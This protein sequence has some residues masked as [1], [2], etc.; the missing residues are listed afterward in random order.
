MTS[1]TPTPIPRYP[2]DW[3]FKQIWPIFFSWILC[4]LA[5]LG[6]VYMAIKARKKSWLMA[7]IIVTPLYA[8]SLHSATTTE[9]DTPFATFG[10]IL[11]CIFAIGFS[12]RKYPEFLKILDER[13][14]NKAMQP[15]P[16]P[17]SKPAPKHS[18]TKTVNKK[19][20]KGKQMVSDLYKWRAEIESTSIR[21]DITQMIKL[22]DIVLKKTGA[23]HDLFFSRYDATLNKLLDKYDEIENTRLNTNDMVETMINIESTIK[24][25]AKAMKQEVS[26]MYKAD[27]LNIN[28]ETSVFLRELKKKGLL[29]E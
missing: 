1:P 29:D 22:S 13:E 21:A 17:T 4:G 11:S 27:L 25:T 7:S 8:I 18:K 19:M 14:K 15:A 3:E 9:G 26:N 20:S 6:L 28:A 12:A 23:D 10:V 24:D 16:E 5:P 2:S